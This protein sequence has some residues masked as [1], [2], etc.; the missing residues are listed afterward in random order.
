MK[1]AVGCDSLIPLI[2]EPIGEVHIALN[3]RYHPLVFEGT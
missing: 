1:K 2:N 3:S